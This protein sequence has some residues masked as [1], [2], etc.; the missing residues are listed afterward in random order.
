MRVAIAPFFVVTAACLAIAARGLLWA[1]PRSTDGIAVID[2]RGQSVVLPRHA[3]RQ[4]VF[5]GTGAGAYVLAT[6]QPGKIVTSA[7]HVNERLKRSTYLARVLPDLSAMRL[8]L[9]EM[10]SGVGNQEVLLREDV[11]VVVTWARLAADYE[12]LGLAV[13]GIPPVSTLDRVARNTEVFASVVERAPEGAATVR[14]ANDARARIA[15][16][17]ENTAG[18]PTRFAALL[19]R[20]PDLWQFG[21]IFPEV[22]AA[23]NGRDL[24]ES[25]TPGLGLDVEAL[26]AL[27]PEVIV[28]IGPN[29]QDARETLLSHPALGSMAAVK[30]RRVVCAPQ[31]LSG[32]MSSIVDV[33]IYASWLADVLHRADQTAARQQVIETLTS[34][35]GERPTDAEINDVLSCAPDTAHLH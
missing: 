18:K 6:R 23:A 20:G 15:R 35:F 28:T 21:L 1:P 14:R 17:I 19:A 30:D 16:D 10:E 33:P 2:G 7:S 34:E 8:A 29:A 12:R 11:D 13:V 22:S 31:G 3:D 32:Y 25:L 27:N 24:R 9:T 5:M 4:A 26:L